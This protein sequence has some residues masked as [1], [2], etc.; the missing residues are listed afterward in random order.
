M[1]SPVPHLYSVYSIVSALGST[2]HVLY[3]LLH[4]AVRLLSISIMFAVFD[5]VSSAIFRN[6]YP[7]MY[8]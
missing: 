8:M 4:R 6:I 7:T 3:L 5:S 2:M 1:I